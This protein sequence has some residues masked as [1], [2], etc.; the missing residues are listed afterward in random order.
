MAEYEILS[1]S[2][3]GDAKETLTLGDA[4]NAIAETKEEVKAT[5]PWGEEVWGTK[6][7]GDRIELSVQVTV[8]GM[9]MVFAVLSILW[10]VLA[11]FKMIFAKAPQPAK[12]APAPK[13]EPKT[14]PAPTPAPAPVAVADDAQLI[15]VITAAVAAYRAAEDPNATPSGF[16]VVSYRRTSGGRAW[17]S[18]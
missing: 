17:N 8:I 16:R 13:A 1:L 18:K 4:T 11:V 12:A 3:D 2:A 5:S 6:P 14:A 7:I 9:V 15:A 10:A